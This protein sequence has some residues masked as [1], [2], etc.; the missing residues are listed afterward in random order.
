LPTIHIQGG[1]LNK[2]ADDGLAA[3]YAA[4]TPFY[5]R[6]FKLVRV[7]SV[8]A[9]ASDETAIE[10]PG[11]VPVELAALRRALGE[12][13]RWEKFN[14]KMEIVA[15]D[16]PKD[17]VE[18]IAAMVGYWK[19]PS[20]AGVIGTPTLRPDGSLLINPGYD[21]A[22]GLVL[23]SPPPMPPIP[24]RP[25]WHDAEAAL[26]V[27]NDLLVD[28][29]FADEVS[30]AV[31]MSMLITPVVRPA[32][33]AAVPIHV[34]DAPQAGTGKSY[35]GDL[36]ASIAIGS[37]CPATP[38]TKDEA[39]L[40][41]RLTAS[42]LAGHPIVSLDNASAP[43]GTSFLNQ[44]IS[45]SMLDLRPLGSSGLV[46]VPNMYSV[47][48]NGNNVTI[49]ADLVRRTLRSLLDANMENPETREFSGDPVRTVLANRG[50]YIAAA[51]TIARAYIVAGRPDRRPKLAGFDVWSDTVRSAL[52]WLNWQDP[53][54]S[55]AKLREDDPHR[56]K[57]A[58]VLDA[59]PTELTEYSTAELIAAATEGN[60]RGELKW[61]QFLE[62]IKA[63]GADRHGNP[64][65][66]A[67]GKWLRD[68]K[69]AVFAGRK[70]TKSGTEKRPR[71]M[72]A[73]AW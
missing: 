11:V 67:L 62:A 56:A 35:L 5:Q 41:K 24:D 26:T 20:L 9:K 55:M 31:A 69:G 48:A 54:D 60:D 40:E 21:A 28:F 13:A 65:A 3:M 64:S 34:A 51:L 38:F 27:L 2:H 30:R 32:L 44:M 43:L 14:A 7:C 4:G 73:D 10:V 18:Q 50:K 19:F 23:I 37:R 52:V 6:A 25:T 45:Q 8:S 49:A 16:P 71:W 22:T 39:E 33:G 53:V 58:A 61:P 1:Q 12:A 47:F 70:L 68:N 63:V 29:P 59:W 42:I 57:V 72:L 36:A 17:V 15:I 66:E 46:R